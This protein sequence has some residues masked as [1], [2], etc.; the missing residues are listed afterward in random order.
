M[1]SEAN[2]ARGI[3]KDGDGDIAK[4][5]AMG[6]TEYE[7]I[8]YIVGAH[9]SKSREKA[10]TGLLAGRSLTKDQVEFVKRVLDRFPV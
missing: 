4:L 8:R 6:I 1:G 5:G 10:L 9:E 3:L 7:V 2:P